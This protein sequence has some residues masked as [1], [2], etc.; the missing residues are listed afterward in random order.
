MFQQRLDTRK[1]K[2]QTTKGT[3]HMEPALPAASVGQSA[4]DL[5]RVC[6]AVFSTLSALTPPKAAAFRGSSNFHSPLSQLEA[7]TN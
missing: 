7:H 4:S 1:N 6:C 5:F 3:E 2:T